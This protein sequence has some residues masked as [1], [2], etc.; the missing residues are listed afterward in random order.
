M[1][2]RRA[3]RLEVFQ[4]EVTAGSRPCYRSGR[5]PDAV[6]A[7]LL[8]SGRAIRGRRTTRRLLGLA[9]HRLAQDDP[10]SIPAVRW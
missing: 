5:N 8:A 6:V 10:A 1:L 4:A 7:R 2:V 9:G 3:A